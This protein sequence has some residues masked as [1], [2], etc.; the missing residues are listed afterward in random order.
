MIVD[1]ELEQWR[2]DWAAQE[3]VAPDLLATVKRQSILLRLA[4]LGEVLVTVVIGGGVIALAL[5]ERAADTTILA[6]GTWT[7][8]AAAWA[9]GL[10][11][12]R[13]AWSPAA[14]ST[15]ECLDLTIRRC[16]ASIRAAAFSI[17][18]FLVEMLFCVAWIAHH[19][20]SAAFLAAPPMILVEVASIFVL[21]GLVVYRARRKAELAR[22]LEM[23]SSL[24]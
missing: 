9:F 15:A 6:L 1:S 7:F 4:L 5:R 3:V 19:N 8:L 18:F 12:R 11:N 20:G 24:C 13:G 14:L 10:W 17:V 21:G 23:R 2:S 16:A 22:F